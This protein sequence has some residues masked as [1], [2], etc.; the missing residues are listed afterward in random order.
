MRQLTK[1]SP[2]H[3]S[4]VGP[5]HYGKSV[6]LQHLAEVFRPGLGEYLT[7]AYWDLRHNTPDTDTDFLKRF[8]SVLKSAL[9]PVNQ[10]LASYIEGTDAPIGDEVALV[11]NELASEKKRL[12]V[13]MDGFDHILRSTSISRSTWDRLLD[14]SRSTSLRLVT[15]SR[16]KLRELCKSEDS[17]TSDFWAIFPNPVRLGAFEE[18]DWDGF[19]L[20]FA[21]RA[22]TFD[23]SARKEL[24]NW[25][26]GI[27]VLA[28]ALLRLAFD[29]TADGRNL[30]KSDIDGF[31]I[32][33]ADD[34]REVIADLWDDCPS[35]TQAEYIDLHTRKE[36]PL[37]EVNEDRRRELEM[38]G[39]AKVAATSLKL[40]ANLV[41]NFAQKNSSGLE[42][43]RRLFGDNDRFSQNVRHLIELR[44][45]SVRIVDAELWNAVKKAIRDIHEPGD[46]LVWGRRISERAFTVIWAKELPG[47]SI[48]E[49]WSRT[50][51]DLFSGTV[52]PS[53]GRACR[54]LQ[55]ATGTDQIPRLT[56]FVSKRTFALINF[57]QSVGDHGQ[58]MSGGEA[59][60]SY[61]ATFCLAAVE[62]CDSLARDFDRP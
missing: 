11:L 26:G 39:L 49:N 29:S 43:M 32:Q 6:V 20:P 59:T 14:F 45:G 47:R 7:S 28:A 27:P 50:L 60:W 44:L 8:G 33:T 61:A 15:G 57:I 10:D 12:L 1:T 56:Q 52:I 19:L 58:H 54:L 16:Q 18:H 53:G 38:R 36:L 42:S 55:L 46:C 35:E 4:V 62:L 5:C 17:A 25:T 48:S 24:V 21:S 30:A 40:S 9:M 13:V 31:A 51:G 34:C 23:S 37:G 41:G 2:D 22:I 3:V